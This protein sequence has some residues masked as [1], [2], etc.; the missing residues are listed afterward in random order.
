MF[1]R[2]KA[3][4]EYIFVVDR[5]GSMQGDRMEMTKEVLMQVLDLLPKDSL[6]QIISFGTHYTQMFQDHS[7]R[8]D[9]ETIKAAKQRISEFSANYGGTEVYF[10]LEHALNA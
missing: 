1:N 4:G 8:S 7:E 9:P 2:E 3:R 6:F 5:S 10:P